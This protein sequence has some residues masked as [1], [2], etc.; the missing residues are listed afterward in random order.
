MPRYYTPPRRA[1]YRHQLVNHDK[2]NGQ[3]MV[4]IVSAVLHHYGAKLRKVPTPQQLQDDFGMS[5]AQAY[6]WVNGLTHGATGA[7]PSDAKRRGTDRRAL[8]FANWP[9][10]RK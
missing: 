6:R 1:A 3:S 2:R 10:P 8:P 4:A 7:Q 9:R 5:R